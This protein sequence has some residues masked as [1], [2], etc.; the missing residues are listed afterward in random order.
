MKKNNPTKKLD[1]LETVII[2]AQKGDQIAFNTLVYHF[3][4]MAVGYAYSILG[5]FHFAEDAAQEAFIS[6]HLKFQQLKTPHSFTGWF[7]SIVFSQ[8]M[9]LIRSKRG[10]TR[11]LPQ[12]EQTA[13]PDPKPD[14]HLEQNEIKELISQAIQSLPTSEREAMVLFYISEYAQAEIAHFLDSRTANAR[15]ACRPFGRRCKPPLRSLRCHI[16]H[17]KPR[18]VR[19]RFRKRCSSS[20][21]TQ[22]SRSSNH[23]RSC[24]HRRHPKGAPL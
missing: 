21:S 9:R 13:S 6:T 18:R 19:R 5:D 15:K 20:A 23:D 16:N 1:N 11:S 4:D 10:E 2:H 17:E 22:K 24:Q 14:E 12:T 8:C 3:Q 7:R